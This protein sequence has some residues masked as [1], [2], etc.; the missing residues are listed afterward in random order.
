MEGERMPIGD[1]LRVGIVGSGK[2]GLLH[3]SLLKIMPGVELA[4]VCEKSSLTRRL[5]KKVFRN[6]SVVKDV[7]ELARLGLD[8]IY[9]TTPTASHFGVATQ[10]FRE[11]LAPNV[12][13]EKPLT[14]SYSDS[15]QL[16]ELASRY[17]GVNMVGYLR[18]FMVTFTKTKELLSQ[19]VIGEPLSFAMNA[20][21][22][23]FMAIHGNPQ[24]SIAR[25]GV[26]NDLGCYAV[27]LALWFFGDLRLTSAKVESLT[28]RNAED[29]AHFTLQQ[30]SSGLEGVVSV[31]WCMEGY[32]MPE[33][34]LFVK[35]SK[36][37]IEVD[38]DRVRMDLSEHDETVWH[39]HDLDDK[40]KFWLGAPEYYREDEYF[41]KKVAAKSLAEP[42]FET[43]SKVDLLIDSV[44]R[45]AR[46]LA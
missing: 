18:R 31:S 4:A 44:Q 30:G 9:V 32:R 37:T 11:H 38:D 7:S 15:K 6:I 28:G 45:R 29:A 26:M 8:L 20:F 27:D 23:D 43:A 22:S 35:G 34:D 36:G 39:R 17:G 16:C 10:V 2:M 46:N 12:F 42:S 3:A 40:V 5:V 25:G 24:A 14:S 13:V 19:G 41:I 1:P 21:S 33:V